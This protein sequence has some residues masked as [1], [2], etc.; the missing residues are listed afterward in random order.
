MKAAGAPN[1]PNLVPVFAEIPS[2]LIKPSEA[3]LKISA[4]SKSEYSFLFE[5]AAT[6]RVGRYS[7]VGAGPR[8][9]IKT[10][11][12]HGE[13]VDP[14]PLLEAELSKS[15]V[16]HVPKLKLPPL[17]GGAI[18]YVGYDCV[19]YFEPKTARPMKDVL[20][21]PESL[22]MLF[23]TIVSF[24]GFYEAGISAVRPSDTSTGHGD[25]P[26]DQIEQSDRACMKK[27]SVPP[28]RLPGLT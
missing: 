19:R 14:L 23:D 16:A 25:T 15:R 10:G 20:K 17:T 3:Y 12:G 6:E 9:I 8:K 18:G 27:V 11:E 1:P 4:H 28:T 22:F 5:S 13:S 7:F 26:I 21:V 2:D 24:D